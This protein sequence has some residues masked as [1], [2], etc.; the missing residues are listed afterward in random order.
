MTSSRNKP[1]KKGKRTEKSHT[2]KEKKKNNEYNNVFLFYREESARE[3][4]SNLIEEIYAGKTIFED[5]KN[6][7]E[8]YLWHLIGG[9]KFHDFLNLTI[10]FHVDVQ[11]PSSRS[12]KK[13]S[14]ITWNLL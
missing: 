4:L 12:F 14:L 1:S 3:R 5:E 11:Y 9:N 13:V 7:I 2:K 6:N 8:I 10:R